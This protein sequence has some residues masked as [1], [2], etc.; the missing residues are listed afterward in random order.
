M[1]S[2]RGFRL[3]HQ[4]KGT[5]I[6]AKVSKAHSD[7]FFYHLVKCKLTVL[8]RIDTPCVNAINIESLELEASMSR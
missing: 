5:E 8:S 7:T 2:N 6:G 3:Q 4:P 1:S